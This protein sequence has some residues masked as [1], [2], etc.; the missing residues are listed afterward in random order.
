MLSLPEKF[1]WIPVYQVT[2]HGRAQ[3]IKCQSVSLWKSFALIDPVDP[4]IEL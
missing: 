2:L 1:P 3:V 4:F